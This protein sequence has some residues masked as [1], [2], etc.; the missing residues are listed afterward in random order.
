MRALKLNSFDLANYTFFVLLCA[1]MV[2][3]IW[4]VLMYSL[5]GSVNIRTNSLFLYPEGLTIE[6]YKYIFRNGTVLRGYKNS[7]IVTGV[8]TAISLALT[9][10]LAFPLSRPRL[11]GKKY[12]MGLVV[13]TMI[14]HGGMIPT[15]LI[16]RAYGLVNTLWALMLP[17]AISVY[18]L[19]IMIRFF[20][21]IPDSLIESAHIDGYNEIATFF[22]IVL[23]L[24]K[25]A[26][27]AIGLFY[28]VHK[29]NAFLP[30]VIYLNDDDLLPIQVILFN[31]IRGSEQVDDAEFVGVDKQAVK[32]ATAFVA[33][34]PILCVYPYLQK[35]FVKGIMLGSVK[36]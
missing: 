12:F 35:Y 24:S 13:F 3:P 36:G 2:Y 16:V 19:L 34:L 27:A 32:M 8:G 14:F 10:T 18:N 28:A 17:L 26:I 23:P 5:S 9:S 21:N 31:L 15:Y 25:P 1:V 7:A 33:M 30:G 4:Y 29:W 11:F 20:R 6:S 22:A